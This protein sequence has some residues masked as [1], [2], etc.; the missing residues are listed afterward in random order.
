MTTEDTA[1]LHRHRRD[2]KK[3][4]CHFKTKKM[5]LNK[6]FYPTP[7]EVIDMMLS[8]IDVTGLRILE[9]SAGSGNIIDWLKARDA[10]EV[11]ACE[12]S[13]D[14]AKVAMQKADRF[15]RRDFLEARSDEISHIDMIV[16]NP[17]FSADEKHI[18]HAYEVAPDGCMIISLCNSSVVERASTKARI[19]IQK[20]IK[21]HG[22]KESFGDCFRGA[23]RS[24][25]V[26][27]SCVWLFKPKSGNQE[28]ADFFSLDEEVEQTQEGLQRYNY[29][30]DMVSRYVDAV[31][32]YDDAIAKAEEI[33]TITATIYKYG[34]KF[35]AYRNGEYSDK[36]IT[37]EEFKKELQKECWKKI[38]ND[39]KMDKYLTKG[40]R[41]V[42]NKF[43]ETQQH[44]P[45]TM[46]NVYQMA[47]MVVGTH[48][49]RMDG[50][51]CEA[52]DMICGFS[53]KDNCTGGEGWKTNSDYMINKKFIVPYVVSVGYSG[54]P[55][56]REGAYSRSR[57]DDI[58]DIVRALC[59]ITHVDY[60]SLP[61][62]HDFLRDTS[63]T[64]GK[65]EYGKKDRTP[66]EWGT[67]HDWAFF[68]IKCFKKG[69]MH[70][71]FLDESVWIEFNKR[72]AEI[73]GWKN[74]VGSRT[75]KGKTV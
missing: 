44:I 34:I 47:Q 40:A 24:T 5:I 27:V 20:L 14:L 73:R 66:A 63:L 13:D 26:E 16:M 6:D 52:F 57:A 56:T 1:A 9:P 32:K 41:G 8:G 45:F 62:L 46:K 67:W 75:K 29:V 23:E 60:D 28:F 2:L 59:Y 43:V 21:E 36:N 69:T 70:F 51:L 25:G 18:L 11:I 58:Q 49:S 19:E 72:I 48:S 71:E 35:G 64:G 17:P 54:Y 31:S 7:Y 61:S 4:K 12:L 53:Y 42:I 74:M 38:F 68:R 37:R 3:N 55:V 50:V 65:S 22:R 39:M 10:Q 30:R 33:N 15:L